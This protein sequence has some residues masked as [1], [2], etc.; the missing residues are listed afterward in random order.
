MHV[1]QQ[2]CPNYCRRRKY[3]G[4]ARETERDPNTSRDPRFRCQ[5]GFVNA[6]QIRTHYFVFDS[7]LITVV[8][9]PRH[10]LDYRMSWY[11]NVR[12]PLEDIVRNIGK[13]VEFGVSTPAPGGPG[14]SRLITSSSR[15][16]SLRSSHPQVF[17]IPT[18]QIEQSVLDISAR[19][20]L[21]HR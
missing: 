13:T 8:A 1:T 11:E 7:H 16:P 21:P 10:R 14:R 20:T 15:L 3:D 9:P 17:S 5:H 6:R 18:H 19:A 2:Y 12:L 4:R